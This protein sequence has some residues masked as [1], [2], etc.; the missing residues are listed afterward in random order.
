MTFEEYIK[1]YR[2]T[3]TYV[4]PVIYPAFGLGG[5]TGE[6]LDIVK[7]AIRHEKL[8]EWNL[9]EKRSTDLFLE[10]GDVLWYWTAL[11]QDLGFDPSAVMQANID[12]LRDRH[13]K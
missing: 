10:L 9:N 7:K 1:T 4:N 13:K 8:P 11:V 3:A 12:K 6:V 2:E 5:E